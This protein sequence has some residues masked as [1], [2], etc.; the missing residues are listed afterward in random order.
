MI[1]LWSIEL[2]GKDTSYKKTWVG[3]RR[4]VSVLS[5]S[6]YVVHRLMSESRETVPQSRLKLV[7]DRVSE[8][9]T[10]DHAVHSESIY[11]MIEE[12]MPPKTSDVILFARV[13]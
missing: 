8:T 12:I 11:K 10:I 6:A 13:R 1:S 7:L 2:R 4:I 5:D 3:R 9:E